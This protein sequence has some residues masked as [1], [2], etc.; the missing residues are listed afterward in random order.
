[1]RAPAVL[2]RKAL[3]ESLGPFNERYLF[4]EDDPFWIKA[5]SEGYVFHYNPD[6]V[7]YYRVAGGSIS[8]TRS[9]QVFSQKFI[10]SLIRYK[11][12][13]ALPLLRKKRMFFWWGV[14][15]LEVEVM[16]FIIRNGNTRSSTINAVLLKVMRIGAKLREF[17]YQG[18]FF[19]R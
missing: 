19:N 17:H 11:K 6:A 10:D 2:I 14:V 18:R 7:V 9:S 15:S 5:L 12:E 4:L 13:I 16:N 1:M 8:Q 3:V